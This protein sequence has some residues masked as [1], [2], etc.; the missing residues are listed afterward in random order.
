MIPICLCRGLD[1]F[2]GGA[3]ATRAETEAYFLAVTWDFGRLDVGHPAMIGT[4]LGVAHVMTKL[5]SFAAVVASHFIYR[6]L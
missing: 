4:P 2:A 6:L 3:Q 1:R 5:P